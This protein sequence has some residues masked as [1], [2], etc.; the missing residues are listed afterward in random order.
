M[1]FAPTL[2][3]EYMG[4]ATTL[5]HILTVCMCSCVPFNQVVKLESSAQSTIETPHI[6]AYTNSRIDKVA[7]VTSFVKK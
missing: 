2:M 5:A 4:I 3:P 7:I 6:T 1:F